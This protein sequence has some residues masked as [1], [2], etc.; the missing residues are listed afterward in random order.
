M[1]VENN[2]K[3]QIHTHVRTHTHTLFAYA[4]SLHEGTQPAGEEDG[5]WKLINTHT[6]N[7]T[8]TCTGRLQG[9]TK[10]KTLRF[11]CGDMVCNPVTQDTL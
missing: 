6:S 4:A 10:A 3:M 2:V 5:R 8:N 9:E 7:F 1:S 11:N